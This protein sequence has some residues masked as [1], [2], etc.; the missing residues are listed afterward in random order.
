VDEKHTYKRKV[1][2]DRYRAKEREDTEKD[3]IKERGRL[4]Y[5]HTQAL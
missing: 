3:E 4:S 2:K 5:T 1:W